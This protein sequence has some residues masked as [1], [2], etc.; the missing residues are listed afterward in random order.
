MEQPWSKGKNGLHSK[1]AC[2]LNLRNHFSLVV[3]QPLMVRGANVHIASNAC[4]MIYRVCNLHIKFCFVQ[5]FTI[6]LVTCY[7]Y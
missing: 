7:D 1:E 3:S 4:L 5:I 6:A 2:A